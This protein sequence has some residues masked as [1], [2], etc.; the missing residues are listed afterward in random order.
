M[1]GT[2]GKGKESSNSP[3]KRKLENTQPTCWL[4]IEKKVSYIVQVGYVSFTVSLNFRM[5]VTQRYL[6]LVFN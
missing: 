1:S 5:F 2:P 4:L 3:C 6:K